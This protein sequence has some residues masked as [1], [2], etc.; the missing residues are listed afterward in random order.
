MTPG[1][2]DA[3]DLASHGDL[4]AQVGMHRHGRRS[5]SPRG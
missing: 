3:D 2:T 1:T 5:V 4:D